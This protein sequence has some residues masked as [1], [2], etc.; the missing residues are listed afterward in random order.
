VLRW[1]RALRA[2]WRQPP[3]AADS[4]LLSDTKPPTP[5][6][7]DA[8]NAL[9]DSVL[10]ECDELRA[11]FKQLFTALYDYPKFGTPFKRG[12]EFSSSF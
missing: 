7:V 6:V 11:P 8:Q 9:T 12:R 3:T 2:L 1:V 4:P 5:Q 10:R